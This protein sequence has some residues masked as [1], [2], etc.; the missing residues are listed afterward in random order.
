MLGSIVSHHSIDSIL[1]CHPCFYTGMKGMTMWGCWLL[2]EWQIRQIYDTIVWLMRICLILGW[3]LRRFCC[4]FCPVRILHSMASS[5]RIC[6]Q[7][8]EVLVSISCSF[9]DHLSASNTCP[10]MNI[11]H[12]PISN[13]LSIL[14]ISHRSRI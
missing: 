4:T 7:M 5:T 6:L 9:P 3:I 8:A 2:S 13:L 12:L 1:C 10:Q 11:Y 14:H